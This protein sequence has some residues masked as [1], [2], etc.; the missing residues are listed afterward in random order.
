MHCAN[1]KDPEQ[2]TI[3]VTNGRLFRDGKVGLWSPWYPDRIRRFVGIEREDSG[4]RGVF[5]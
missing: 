3:R 2:R 1:Q 4:C 5:L